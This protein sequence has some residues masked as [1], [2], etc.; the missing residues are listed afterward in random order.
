MAFPTF[1]DLREPAYHSG[2]NEVALPFQKKI[3][4]KYNSHTVVAALQPNTGL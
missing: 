3:V 2:Y 1:S 4:S